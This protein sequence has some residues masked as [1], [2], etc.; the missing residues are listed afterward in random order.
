MDATRERVLILSLMVD[1]DDLLVLD[2]RDP[3][4]VTVRGDH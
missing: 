4:L 2:H 3:R 1:L